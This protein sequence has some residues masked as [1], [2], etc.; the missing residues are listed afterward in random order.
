[1]TDRNT[2]GVSVSFGSVLEPRCCTND[3][4]GGAQC[5]RD[6]SGRLARPRKW[7]DSLEEVAASRAGAVGGP[8]LTK[9][10]N[11]SENV[12][13]GLGRPPVCNTAPQ[14]KNFQAAISEPDL[15]T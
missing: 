7:V 13:H 15:F 3:V 1:M 4:R 2:A 10:K 12:Q 9:T 6:G 11:Y 8:S 5:L 14:V